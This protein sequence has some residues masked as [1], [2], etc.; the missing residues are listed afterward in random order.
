[1]KYFFCMV[2][3]FLVYGCNE[4]ATSNSSTQGNSDTTTLRTSIKTD[5]LKVKDSAITK[6]NDTSNLKTETSCGDML[7]RLIKTSS[8]DSAVKKIEFGLL[9]DQVD[10]GVVRIELTT[11]NTKRNEEVALT[12]IE[13]DLNKKELRDVTIDPDKPI[14]LSYD[15]KLFEHIAKSCKW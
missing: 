8:V 11:R 4:S 10:S 14:Q 13:M 12:W 6:N 1:M 15:K 5:S 7:K 9:I 3:L 2:I